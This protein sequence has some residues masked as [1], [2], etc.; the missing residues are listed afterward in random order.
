[1]HATAITSEQLRK[2]LA[3]GLDAAARARMPHVPEWP[4]TRD[5][6]KRRYE[7]IIATLPIELRDECQ[8]DGPGEA[9][10]EFQLPWG[11]VRIEFSPEFEEVDGIAKESLDIVFRLDVIEVEAEQRTLAYE[12][13]F[14]AISARLETANLDGFDYVVHE[15]CAEPGFA[16][17][18][19][20]PGIGSRSIDL[21][22]LAAFAGNIF[23][24]GT[25]DSAIQQ[26]IR[27]LEAPVKAA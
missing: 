8:E 1:M 26:V 19:F 10:P 13:F 9:Q 12:T 5:A 6:R 3:G 15:A 17:I 18:V 7:E 20:V 11:R 22:S 24:N 14:D 16:S 21:S 25:V 2:I 27:R 23:V 4:E